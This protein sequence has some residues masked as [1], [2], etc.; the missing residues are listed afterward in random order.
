MTLIQT[1]LQNGS[2]A[3]CVTAA[4]GP[5]CAVNIIVNT[6]AA[7]ICLLLTDF[8]SEQHNTRSDRKGFLVAKTEY[9]TQKES[10]SW[11]SE[12]AETL[13][14]KLDSLQTAARGRAAGPGGRLRR[15]RPG[16]GH[17]AGAVLGRGGYLQQNIYSRYPDPSMQDNVTTDYVIIGNGR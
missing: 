8:Y 14:R 12:G 13:R 9:C 3:S 17:G 5:V 2:L 4:D 15:Q 6:M 16:C 7:S 1:I 10:Q 11:S